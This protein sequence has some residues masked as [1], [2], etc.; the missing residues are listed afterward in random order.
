MEN[1]WSIYPKEHFVFDRPEKF[2]RMT[3]NVVPV[4]SLRREG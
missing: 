3:A 4:N 2:N 1:G